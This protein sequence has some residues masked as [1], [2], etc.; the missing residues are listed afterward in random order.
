MPK[1]IPPILTMKGDTKKRLT[2]NLVS[3][4]PDKT[5]NIAAIIGH[6]AIYTG[7]FSET[8]IIILDE[9]NANK[10]IQPANTANTLFTL[11][12]DKLIHNKLPNANCQTRVNVV[13][14]AHC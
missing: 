5:I 8:S 2:P 4:V 13:K 14:Y 6:N 7:N 10:P 1:E 3:R 11:I 9:I 12:D